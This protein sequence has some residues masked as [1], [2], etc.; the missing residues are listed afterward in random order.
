MI[1]CFEL[2]KYA[3][4]ESWEVKYPNAMAKMVSA[5]TTAQ[6]IVFFRKN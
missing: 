3:L 5:S 6:L 1:Y 4:F 2:V